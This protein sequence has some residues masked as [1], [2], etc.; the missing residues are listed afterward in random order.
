MRTLFTAMRRAACSYI[1]VTAAS[2][3]LTVAG[4]D[5]A[6]SM[7]RFH[8]VTAPSAQTWSANASP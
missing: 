3:G 7:S 6:A 2:A 4:L 1:S 8:A 5:L